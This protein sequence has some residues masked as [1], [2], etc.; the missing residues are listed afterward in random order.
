MSKPKP[1]L[2]D[3]ADVLE[4][5]AER[6]SKVEGQGEK[7]AE[8]VRMSIVYAETKLRA[9]RFILARSSP[10]SRPRLLDIGTQI[11]SLPLYASR[12]GI[13]AAGLDYAEFAPDCERILREYGVDYRVGDIGR[14]RLP[15]A[16]E[17]F[18][19]VTYMDVIEHHPYSPKRVLHEVRRVLTARGCVIITT[20]NH[21]SIY[22]RLSLLRG[23]S[24][25]DTFDYFFEVSKDQS[26]YFG[27]HRE[28]T[29][30][31]LRT[32]LEQTGFHVL[33][34][35]GIDEGI[36]AQWRA[37]RLASLR[38]RIAALREHGKFLGANVL[39]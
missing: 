9:L 25:N 24:V 31:E 39:G 34:C 38:R 13:E 2:D 5:L 27:H 36:R 37:V 35:A 17:S 19:C 10:G 20:P 3:F 18:D 33:Q 12:L 16:D 4:L 7:S 26:I 23:R 11:G 28:Y 21:A 22:N 30:I 32:A 14:E 29:R 6:Y 1:N 15:F 8:W